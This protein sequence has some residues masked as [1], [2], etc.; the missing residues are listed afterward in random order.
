MREIVGQCRS[1]Q[2]L[3]FSILI[4]VTM[5]KVADVARQN[6]RLIIPNNLSAVGIL[7]FRGPQRVTSSFQIKINFQLISFYR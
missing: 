5:N 1:K 7:P 6:W 2:I 3:G 4:A